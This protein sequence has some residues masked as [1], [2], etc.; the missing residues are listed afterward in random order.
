M[1]GVNLLGVQMEVFFGGGSGDG[2]W[3]NNWDNIWF[4][5]IVQYDDCWVVEMVIFFKMLWY[6]VKVIIWGINFLCNDVK[7]NQFYVWVFILR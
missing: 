6:E 2:N 3:N 7:C 1:F 5:E 4:V